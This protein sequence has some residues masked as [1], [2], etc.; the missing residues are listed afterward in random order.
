MLKESC[1]HLL[2][3]NLLEL[4]KL[5]ALLIGTLA[6]LIGLKIVAVLIDLL[7]DVNIVLIGR[8]RMGFELFTL[9]QLTKAREHSIITEILFWRGRRTNITYAL[10]HLGKC[11]V[12]RSVSTLPFLAVGRY[13]ANTMP[14]NLGFVGHYLYVF[15]IEDP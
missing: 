6:P 1:L 9:T 11:N 5:L 15:V 12:T 4:T 3:R 10:A 8:F 14:I 2:V 7:L 13:V